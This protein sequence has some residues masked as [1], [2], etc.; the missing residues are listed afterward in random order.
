MMA[1]VPGFG[2][3]LHP[4]AVLESFCSG[5]QETSGRIALQRNS[6]IESGAGN[7]NSLLPIKIP[8]SI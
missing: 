6:L 2:S 7:C 3:R 4:G 5:I 1:T 8:C